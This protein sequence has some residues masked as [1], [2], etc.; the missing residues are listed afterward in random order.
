MPFSISF[1][2]EQSS[3]VTTSSFDELFTPT[4]TITFTTFSSS[5]QTA[6]FSFTTAS[7]SSRTFID[8]IDYATATPTPTPDLYGYIKGAIPIKD[9]SDRFWMDE[10][11]QEMNQ[12]LY[13]MFY[14]ERIQW[15]D[16]AI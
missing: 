13:D 16:L 7:T 2:T 9:E 4:P 8:P 10:Y 5:S 14:D 6:S 3:P 1:I 12:E 11:E 15:Q